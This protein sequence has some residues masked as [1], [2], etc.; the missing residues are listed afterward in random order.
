[1]EIFLADECRLLR[2]S[3]LF[4]AGFMGYTDFMPHPRGPDEPLISRTDPATVFILMKYVCVYLHIKN[5]E[6]VRACTL[7]QDL[8]KVSKV[9]GLFACIILEICTLLLS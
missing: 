8:N 6:I 9:I 3:C 2:P 5:S 1:M 4:V 7:N